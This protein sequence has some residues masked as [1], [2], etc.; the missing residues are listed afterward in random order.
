MIHYIHLSSDLSKED[1]FQ[2][3]SMSRSCLKSSRASK[4]TLNISLH[5]HILL[6]FSHIELCMCEIC[7]ELDCLAKPTTKKQ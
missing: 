6:E 5:F 2:E 7:S 3:V 4:I 1:V